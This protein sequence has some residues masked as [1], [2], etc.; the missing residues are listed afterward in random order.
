MDPTR[1]RRNVSVNHD[2]RV[3]QKWAFANSSTISFGEGGFIMSPMVK[4]RGE[5]APSSRAV[6]TRPRRKRTVTLERNHSFILAFADALRD[7]LREERRRV[8]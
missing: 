8:A 3:G 4:A 5:R 6:D 2:V 1:S 7:I